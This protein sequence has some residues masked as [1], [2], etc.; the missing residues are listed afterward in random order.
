MSLWKIWI[1]Q[2]EPTSAHA[3]GM[4]MLHLATST[5]LLERLWTW[6]NVDIN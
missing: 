4:V 2:A 5:V 6:K 1:L 3:E